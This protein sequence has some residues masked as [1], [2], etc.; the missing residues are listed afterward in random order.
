MNSPSDK[1]L[2]L[3]VDDDATT[4]L[5]AR[6]CLA[7]SGFE[8]DLANDGESGLERFRTQ[9]PDTVLLDVNMPGIDG[10][11]LCSMLR[12]IPEG[13]QVPILM[14]TGLDDVESIN[15]AFE[16]GATDFITKPINWTLLG[17]RVQY[18]LRASN[19]IVE[20][21]RSEKRLK[22][23]QRIAQIGDW[24]FETAED[25]LYLSEQIFHIL[26]LEPTRGP[27]PFESFLKSV[28]REDLSKVRG[29]MH[30]AIAQRHSFEIEHR[31]VLPGGGVRVL[32]QQGE[33][34]S[35]NESDKI[36]KIVGTTQDITDRKKSEEQIRQLAYFD[37]LTYL[38]NRVFFTEQ[39]RLALEA[40]AQW[41]RRVAV[42]FLDL[43]NFKVI[44]DTLGHAV[45]DALLEAIGKR[46]TNSVR[47]GDSSSRLER[48]LL[49]S[50]ASTSIAR[51]GGD[52]FTLLLPDV[53]EIDEICTVAERILAT[54]SKPLVLSGNEVF[55]SASIGIALYPGDGQDVNEL[56]MNADAAMYHAKE[57]GRNNFQFYDRSMSNR[58]RE[59][60]S[61]ETGLRKAVERDEFRLHYQP[62]VEIATGRVVGMEALLRWVHPERGMVSPAEFIPVAEK[63]GLIVAIGEWVIDSACRQAAAW[64]TM[65]LQTLPIAVNISSLHFNRGE[66]VETIKR[67]LVAHRCPADLL[68]LEVTESLLMQDLES[69]LATLQELKDLGIRLALDDFGTGYSSFSYLK[70]LPLHTLKIDRSFIR[71][72]VQQR[73]DASITVA[74]IAMAHSMNLTVVAE[75]VEDPLQ[76]AF[77]AKH[78]CDQYQGFYFSPPLDAEVLGRLLE[79]SAVPLVQ[80]NAVPTSSGENPE[81]PV[82]TP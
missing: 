5:L 1:P 31:I 26:G 52:E 44:N 22:N 10:F 58:A 60:L 56:L 42:I 11:T 51:I 71:S 33:V 50:G 61:L 41:G 54:I 8:T 48:G 23:A 82:G 74:L 76:L 55:V 21:K 62:K 57:E 46:L 3:I 13:E 34:S 2:V 43:D 45:G 66:L 78:G 40:A 27:V 24:E 32:H 38:P 19:A 18:V 70:R 12:A 79:A 64:R 49:A 39:M 36:D 17:H 30:H 16:L 35:A 75:G 68:E 73:D 29:A 69:V 80:Q 7:R 15:R 28:H 20:V 81:V 14:L 65:G 47:G 9:V 63:M 6:A 59:R 67:C 72:V 53:K 77:L 4:R 25:R 37:P